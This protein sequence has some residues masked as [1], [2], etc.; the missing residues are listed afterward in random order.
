MPVGLDTNALLGESS[1]PAEL[2]ARCRQGRLTLLTADPQL[3][4]LA[5]VT[6]YPKIRARLKPA[7]AGRLVNDV[8]EIAEI[9]E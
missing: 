6:R 7:L 3:N 4:E 8:H 2:V 9:V 5:R 1:P